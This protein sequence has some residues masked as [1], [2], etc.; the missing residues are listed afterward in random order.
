M[1]HTPSCI[2]L[3]KEV[4]IVKVKVTVTRKGQMKPISITCPQCSTVT[5]TTEEHIK[6]Y[7][8]K[9]CSGCRAL[10]KIKIVNG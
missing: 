3:F 4:T 7:G 6:I 9:T 8:E 1:V 2:I 10:L 5:M